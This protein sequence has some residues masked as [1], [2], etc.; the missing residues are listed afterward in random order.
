MA[1]NTDKQAIENLADNFHGHAALLR[2]IQ[3]RVLIAQ[4]RVIYATNEEILWMYWDIDICNISVCKS[5]A[6][7]GNPDD[8][9]NTVRQ[10][11][12]KQRLFHCKKSVS[13]AKRLESFNMIN[14]TLP[15]H[16]FEID[17]AKVSEPHDN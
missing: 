16:F 1:K 3:Q 11:I 17:E 10:C 7:L 9:S 6:L 2:K 5:I 12:Q 15:M 4:Q 8:L 14:L 13:N